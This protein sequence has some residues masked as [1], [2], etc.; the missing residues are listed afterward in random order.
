MVVNRVG[1][2][3]YRRVLVTGMGAVTPFGA[4]VDLMWKSLI[5]GQSSITELDAFDPSPYGTR[6]AGQA[7]DFRPG[8]FLSQREIS[9]SARCVQFALASARM[10]LDDA[11]FAMGATDTARVG[12]FI[13]TSVGTAEYLAANHAIFLDKGIRRVHPLF[14]ALSYNG[15]VAT[16]LSIS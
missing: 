10:A 6:V 14:P 16:Q 12:V 11:R 2:G 4:G 7:R 3:V 13:G 15:V 1:S 9:G 5:H 8:D